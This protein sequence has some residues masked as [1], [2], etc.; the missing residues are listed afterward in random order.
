M[1]V[2]AP[3]RDVPTCAATTAS[4]GQTSTGSGAVSAR[5]A[6]TARTAPPGWRRSA[7]TARTMTEVRREGG[8]W[9]LQLADIPSVW[10]KLVFY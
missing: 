6:G 10:F 8:V 1:D 3:L 5:Q 4:A 2:T 7:V 9:G